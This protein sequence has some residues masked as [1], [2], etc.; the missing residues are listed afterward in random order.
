MN[1]SLTGS[2][3][4]LAALAQAPALRAQ[5][6]VG[7]EAPSLTPDVWLNFKE[8]H[9]KSFTQLRGSAVLLDYWQTW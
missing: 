6:N 3:L 1:R 8:F 4:L 2:A 5:A 9:G 7:K